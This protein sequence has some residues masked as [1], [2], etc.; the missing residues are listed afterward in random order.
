ML[1]FD[2]FLNLIRFLDYFLFRFYVQLCKFH[3]PA[4]I[5]FKLCHEFSKSISNFQL[6]I[7]KTLTSLFPGTTK[8]IV[9]GDGKI[10]VYR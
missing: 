9:P 3:Q 6:P 2:Y 1:S 7:D 10:F 5:C 8:D 4:K